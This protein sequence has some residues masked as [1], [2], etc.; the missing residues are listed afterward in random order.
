MALA[1]TD[2]HACVRTREPRTQPET[3]SSKV[4]V[5]TILS[6][7]PHLH[8]P[9]LHLI[10]ESRGAALIMTSPSGQRQSR[11]TR[12]IIHCVTGTVRPQQTRSTVDEDTGRTPPPAQHSLSDLFLCPLLPR[13]LPLNFCSFR[14]SKAAWGGSFS[15]LP[16][17][18]TQQLSLSSVTP[19]PPKGTFFPLCCL[20]RS[21]YSEGQMNAGIIAGVEETFLF[22]HFG[23]DYS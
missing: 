13:R 15:F 23:A 6:N 2:T 11:R 14:K 1:S 17:P 9:S 20:Q 12:R 19:L 18:E 10:P 8:L 4:C 3:K 7:N 22:S 5:L 21:L 16:I